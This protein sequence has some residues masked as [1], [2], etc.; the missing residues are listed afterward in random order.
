MRLTARFTVFI[1]TLLLFSATAAAHPSY[2]RVDRILID[3]TGQEV[4]IVKYYID[5]IAF[6]DPVR[7]IVRDQAGVILAETD[8]GRDVSVICW[9]ASDYLVFRYDGFFPV[10][11]RDVWILCGSS[12]VRTDSLLLYLLGV[13]VPFW[14]HWRGYLTALGVFLIP[15][16]AHRLVKLVK[17]VILRKVLLVCIYVLG[18]FLLLSWL[19]IVVALSYLSLPL[20]AGLIGIVLYLLRKVSIRVVLPMG[21]QEAKRY[22]AV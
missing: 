22:E 5:G 6:T 4:H 3:K 1:L 14:D 18:G 13:V 20:C 17:P 2:E 19:Y 12:L 21:R 8:F 15:F 10:W 11:P 7:L 9:T 16:G